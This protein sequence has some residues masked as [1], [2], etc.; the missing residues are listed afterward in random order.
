M[1]YFMELITTVH[2]TQTHRE[3]LEGWIQINEGGN[4]YKEISVCV[5]VCVCGGYICIRMLFSECLQ[6]WLVKTRNNIFCRRAVSTRVYVGQIHRRV[7]SRRRVSRGAICSSQASPLFILAEAQLTRNHLINIY[8]KGLNRE[9]V[10]F[11]FATAGASETA[12]RVV[13]GPLI[14]PQ[15]FPVIISSDGFQSTAVH[16]Y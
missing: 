1:A 15:L 8:I 6:S 13:F 16:E 14:P 2:S 7:P 10:I 3:G 4:W 9:R 11:S 12:W 5:C